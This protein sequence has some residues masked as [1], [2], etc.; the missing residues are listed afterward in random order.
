[1]VVANIEARVLI[2][3]ASPHEAVDRAAVGAVAC[4]GSTRRG[5]EA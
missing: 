4:G 5:V 1:V 2:P 3:W